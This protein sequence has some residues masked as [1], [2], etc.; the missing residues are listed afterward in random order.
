ME[1]VFN[2]PLMYVIEYPAQDVVEML[3]K[4]AGRVGVMRGAVAERFRHDF[5]IFL[6]AERNEEQLAEFID[7]Y[8]AVLDQPVSRH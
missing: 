5:G 8:S 1:V 7:A 2:H 4:R 6:S 3:D